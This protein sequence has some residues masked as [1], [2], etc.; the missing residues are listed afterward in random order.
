MTSLLVCG[1][2]KH[3]K[4]P[5]RQ[6]AKNKNTLENGRNFKTVND[7]IK[8]SIGWITDEKSWLLNE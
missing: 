5:F 3:P 2:I 7:M 6:Y 8:V 4:L 1:V